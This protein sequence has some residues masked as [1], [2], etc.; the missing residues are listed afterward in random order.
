MSGNNKTR[1]VR[2][3]FKLLFLNLHTLAQYPFEKYPA[4]R[5]A[6]YKH[7][8]F[9]YSEKRNA[10]VAHMFI[11][12]FF[13]NGDNLHIESYTLDRADTSYIC[14]YRNKKLIRKIFESMYMI[15]R[16]ISDEPLRVAD[17]NGDSLKDIKLNVPYNG[18]GIA[19]MNCR[20]IYLFQDS[21]KGFR[22][23]SFM[24]KI[25]ENRSERDIDGDGNFEIITMTL[26]GHGDHNYWLFNLYN[27]KR[28]KLV[29]ENHK[30]E[31]PIMVQL[32][33][34]RNYKVT[35]KLS[36]KQIQRYEMKLPQE[37]DQR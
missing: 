34:R 16:N 24:D 1:F 26:Q 30:A 33:Y 4:V 12:G 6:E 23:I 5:Y 19:A 17:I 18:C 14:L 37:Y 25:A 3:L 21:A 8:A 29:N 31:Y 27:Y 13:K 7:W 2:F 9:T 32:L 22:K 10:M 11:R 20:T 15:R 36:R 28:G 35:N